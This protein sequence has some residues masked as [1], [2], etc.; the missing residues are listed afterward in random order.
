MDGDRTLNSLPAE[1]SQS[2]ELS[3]LPNDVHKSDA[4]KRKVDDD[5]DD[6]QSERHRKKKKKV[7]CEVI[8]YLAPCLIPFSLR[9]K[10]RERTRIEIISGAEA[11]KGKGAN[12]RGIET[13]SVV[14]E[15]VLIVAALTD[16]EKKEIAVIVIETVS[17]KMRAKNLGKKRGKKKNRRRKVPRDQKIR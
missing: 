8:F 17:G 11:G 7:S 1:I 14:E 12:E 2:N 6:D 10:T 13:K 5:S 4:D 3:V 16:A 15:I 9:V